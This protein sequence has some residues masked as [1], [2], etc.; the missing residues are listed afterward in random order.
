MAGSDLSGCVNDVTNIR[1]SL[2]KFFGFTIDDIRVVTDERATKR[3]I[4]ER[5]AWL[6]KGAKTWDRMVF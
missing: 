1:D 4:M 2:I 3:A 5:L 6:V